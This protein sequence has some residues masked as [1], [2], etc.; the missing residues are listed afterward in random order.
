MKQIIVIVIMA[1]ALISCA[2]NRPNTKNSTEVSSH[3]KHLTLIGTYT[4]DIESGKLGGSGKNID[5]W[6]EKIDAKTTNLIPRNGATVEITKKSFASLDKAY[7]KQFP[8][9][10]DGKVSNSDIKV[11]TVVM[12]KTAEGNYGKLRIIGFKSS[13]DF[14]YKEAKEYINDSY[15]K[16]SLSRPAIK[17]YSVVIEYLLL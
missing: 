17:K 16:F 14:D 2:E 13:H 11:G 1:I 6:L 12:F 10:R 4:L 8:I 5:F 7:M 15:K 3:T 9:F